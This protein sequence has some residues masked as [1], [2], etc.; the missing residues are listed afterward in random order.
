MYR[1]NLE[2]FRMRK[3][4]DSTLHKKRIVTAQEYENYETVPITE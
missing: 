4:C 1:V 3:L 2:K